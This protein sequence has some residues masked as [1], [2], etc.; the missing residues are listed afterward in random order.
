MDLV[1]NA[2]PGATLSQKKR[3]LD[4]RA[5]SILERCAVQVGSGVKHIVTPTEDDQKP[6][7]THTH[8]HTCT[9]THRRTTV[10]RHLRAFE[11]AEEWPKE[12][13][14]QILDDLQEHVMN[15]PGNAV[16]TSSCLRLGVPS[17]FWGLVI[18]YCNIL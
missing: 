18:I 8:I 15:S 2:W 9:H 10:G 14:D 12:I 16:P 5:L 7:H 4:P 1:K 6:Q 3:S 17:R 11:S 13:H